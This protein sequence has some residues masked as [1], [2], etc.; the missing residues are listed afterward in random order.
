MIVRSLNEVA[1]TERETLAPT[2]A[3]RRL[4]LARDGLGFS[5]HDTILFAGTTT[6]MRYKNHV[7]SV[8]CVEGEGELTDLETGEVHAIR[9][10]VLY[11][12]DGHERHELRAITDLRMMCVFNPPLTGQEV[13][14]EEH[15]YPLLLDEPERTTA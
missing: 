4:I 12:L 1:G 3:S 14:D 2:F 6:T 7:E 11:A 13:H 8:Y 9:P 15:S 5:F 10:G